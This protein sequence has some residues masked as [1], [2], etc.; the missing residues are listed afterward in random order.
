MNMSFFTKKREVVL[1]D[2]C[3]D[4]YERFI[5]NPVVEGYDV[6]V[7]YL[8]K[9]R[10]SVVE[11]DGNF[12]DVTTEELR[13][14][15]IPLRFELFALA[16]IHRFGDKSA[17]PQSEFTKRYLREIE[18]E[19]IWRDSEPYNQ[20]VARSV[21]GGKNPSRASDRLSVGFVTNMRVELF[22]QY[23]KAGYDDECV[24]RVLN[25]LMVGD[26]RK[27]VRTPVYLMFVLCNKLGFG[28]DFSPNDEAGFRLNAVILGFYDGAH[29]GLDEVKIRH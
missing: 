8:D 14:A 15:T 10:E 4:C 2:F 24:A 13:A 23:H 5:L 16:W 11:A 18:R 9:V 7:A 1:E 12:S 6:G 20:A 3:R 25:R 29:Q 27:N 28:G 22:K 26:L 19:D 21:T 17:I